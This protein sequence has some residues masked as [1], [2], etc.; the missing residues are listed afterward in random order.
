[1]TS[2]SAEELKRFGGRLIRVTVG[3]DHLQI[4]TDSGL[5]NIFTLAV[6]RALQGDELGRWV[7]NTSSINAGSRFAALIPDEIS[8]TLLIADGRLTIQFVTG[9]QLEIV[10]D[11]S[12]ERAWEAQGRDR[13]ITCWP[14]T[15]GSKVFSDVTGDV[16]LP[17]D[18][19]G[20]RAQSVRWTDSWAAFEKDD[21]A[22]S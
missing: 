6:A 12:G 10:P 11:L 18:E 4:R 13:S 9:E 22:P 5:V 16:A 2:N 17:G 8:K 14:N 20:T 21:Q 3:L 7:P 1:M 19:T 15:D